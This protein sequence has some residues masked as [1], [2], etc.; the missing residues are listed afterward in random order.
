MTFVSFDKIKT[1][2]YRD[3]LYLKDEEENVRECSKLGI[4]YTIAYDNYIEAI[5]R[6]A[7]H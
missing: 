5:D 4:S 7:K 3:V 6:V 2:L 1:L